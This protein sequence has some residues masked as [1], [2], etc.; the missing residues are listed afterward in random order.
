MRVERL[1]KRDA[2]LEDAVVSGVSLCGVEGMN[3]NLTLSMLSSAAIEQRLPRRGCTTCSPGGA[4]HP[5]A[6]NTKIDVQIR[7][8]K[9]QGQSQSH[10][11]KSHFVPC[12]FPSIAGQWKRCSFLLECLSPLR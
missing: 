12:L 5:S 4:P 1:Y 3:P 6:S 8:V 10:Q 11:S 2:L 9:D 7:E